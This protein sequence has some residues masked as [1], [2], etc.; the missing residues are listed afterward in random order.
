MGEAS[1]D[2]VEE[3]FP[4][5]GRSSNFRRVSCGV[6]G[7]DDVAMRPRVNNRFKWAK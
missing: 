1:G 3:V 2:G 6:G 5:R 4:E 7:V